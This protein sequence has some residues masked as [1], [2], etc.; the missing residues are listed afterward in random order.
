M[1]EK[2]NLRR[3]LESWRG[4]GFTEQE[5]AKFDIT[6]LL[7]MPC[8]L[9]I[10]HKPGK[11]DPS[12]TYVEISSISKLPKGLDCPAPLNPSV[13]LEY[14]NWKPEVFDSLSEFL[15]EK[16]QSSEEYKQM[17]GGTA[18]PV[19]VDDIVSDLPF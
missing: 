1:H 12:K 7:G 9:N 18:D 5:A 17:N 11:V 15:K 8:M 13:R 4:M 19:Q 2:S 3:D 6:K 16:I 14:D 10:I